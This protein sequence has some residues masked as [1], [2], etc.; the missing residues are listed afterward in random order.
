MTT[1]FLSIRVAKNVLTL[2]RTTL[3]NNRQFRSLLD[4]LNDCELNF[5]DCSR[6]VR[7]MDFNLAEFMGGG[8]AY[9]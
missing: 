4:N 2:I 6:S 5:A 7:E 3:G 8:M 9:G 1:C